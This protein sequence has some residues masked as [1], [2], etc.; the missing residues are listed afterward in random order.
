ML[1]RLK[2]AFTENLPLKL[3]SLAVALVLFS[4]VH[5]GQ[6]AQRTVP[7]G[8]VV[9][10][11]PDSMNRVLTTTPPS[12]IRV[13]VRGSR[14]VIDELRPEDLGDVQ[15][16]LRSGQD[17]RVVLEQSLLRVP[18]GVRV[19]RFDPSFI[20]FSWEEQVVR[21]IPVQVGVVGA[22]A[23]GWV[24]RGAPVPEP[25]TVRVKGPKSEVLVLQHA[26]ADAFDVTGLSEGTHT[27]VLALDKPGGRVTYD[28]TSVSASMELAREVAERSFTKLP[29]AVVGVPKGKT[30]PAEVDARLVCPPDVVHALRAEQLVPQVR[31]TQPAQNGSESLPVDL[32]VDKC[33]VQITPRTVVVRW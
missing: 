19:D 22:P 30:Q 5:G 29:V 16:D 31:L 11:P 9:L 20:E 17:K 24:V 25:R 10:P 26:R 14:S 8:L 32:A 18:A 28:A 21:D 1:E 12:E 7:V 6:D 13:T 23:P 3:L 4:L 27:K 15:I 2:A 33:D